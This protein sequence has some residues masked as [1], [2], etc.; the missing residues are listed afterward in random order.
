MNQLLTEPLQVQ[1][2]T[3]PNAVM[4]DLM[5]T[6]LQRG[7]PFRFQALGG[8]MSPLIRAGDV[9]FVNPIQPGEPVVGQ[10]VAFIHPVNC[11]LLIHRV[12]H[13]QGSVLLMQGDNMGGRNDGQ[14]PLENILGCVARVNRNGRCVCYG[15]GLLGYMIAVFSQ[16]GLL[17]II[18][19]GLRVLAG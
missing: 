13:R 7:L 1:E 4:R 5:K 16:L 2:L 15:K 3:L 10:V 8:S 9:V 6:S 12:I 14:V 19:K 11:L 18:L 17:T